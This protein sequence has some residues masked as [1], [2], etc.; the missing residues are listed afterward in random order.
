VLGLSWCG[1]LPAVATDRWV[2]L[3][4]DGTLR[5]FADV[6]CGPFAAIAPYWVTAR[7]PSLAVGTYPVEFYRS[8]NG[9]P[10]TSYRLDA[11]ATLEVIPDRLDRP[12]SE[13]TE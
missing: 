9:D 3:G 12:G 8:F 2:E 10:D 6:M 1:A 11:S 5:L 4:A 7:L 13:A